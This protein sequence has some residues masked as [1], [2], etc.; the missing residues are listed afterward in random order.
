MSTFV[1]EGGRKI[2]GTL[3]VSGNKNEALPL[4]AASILFDSAVVLTNV[5]DI[6]DVSTMLSIAA[7]LG[8][9]VSALSGGSVTIHAPGHITSLV[10]LELSRAIRGSFLFA[11]SLLV[12]T[13]KAVLTQPGGD[14][15]GRRRL[16]THLLVFKALG[17]RLRIT[18]SGAKNKEQVTYTLEARKGLHGA[19]IY[20]DEASVTAT[21]NAVI[22]AAGAKGTTTITN[23]A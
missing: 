11:S 19:Q 21:E 14:A 17:A 16:D 2:A 1:V 8:A 5:P 20:L 12:R 18:Q 6:G 23:A 7:H 4:I 22:A 13:G 3:R 9:E 15:I 10:P